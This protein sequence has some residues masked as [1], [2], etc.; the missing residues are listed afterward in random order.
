MDVIN[1]QTV[2]LSKSNIVNKCLSL[3]LIHFCLLQLG[4][5]DAVRALL[6]A[7]SDPTIPNSEGATSFD[8]CTDKAI[9]GVYNEELLQAAANSK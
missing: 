7:G 6:A 1:S 9:L 5:T 8:Y 4:Y 3:K 2:I